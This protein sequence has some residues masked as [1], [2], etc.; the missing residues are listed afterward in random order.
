[1]QIGKLLPL[2]RSQP[3]V[4]AVQNIPV[5]KSKE[6]IKYKMDRESVI[7]A[8]FDKWNEGRTSLLLTS[9]DQVRFNS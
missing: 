8:N 6:D 3:V 1:M 9:T 5:T 2:P 4:P 7:K